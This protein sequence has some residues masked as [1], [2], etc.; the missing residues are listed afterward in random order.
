[1]DATAITIIL[2]AVSLLVVFWALKHHRANVSR[3]IGRGIRLFSLWLRLD[4]EQKARLRELEEA[5]DGLSKE[6]VSRGAGRAAEFT[7]FVESDEID[8]EK[9]REFLGSHREGLEDKVADLLEKY[10]AF[11]DSLTPEQREKLDKK[12]RNHRPRLAFCGHRR[13]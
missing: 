6:R 13:S 3:R 11:R 4:G 1:M 2:V 5:F 8:R 10:K 7:E 9:L 12:A